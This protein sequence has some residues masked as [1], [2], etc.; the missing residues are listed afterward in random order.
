[1]S[2][3]HH[4][5]QVLEERHFAHGRFDPSSVRVMTKNPDKKRPK[6]RKTPAKRTKHAQDRPPNERRSPLRKALESFESPFVVVFRVPSTEKSISFKTD[7]FS[8]D[9]ET[10]FSENI[11]QFSKYPGL[12]VEARVA[13]HL[14]IVYVGIHFW[15]IRSDFFRKNTFPTTSR[16]SFTWPFPPRSS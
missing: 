1:M 13:R 6:A 8:N 10:R 14:R 4:H 16:A 15:H 9:R 7:R 11:R 3:S 5:L 12:T 2:T